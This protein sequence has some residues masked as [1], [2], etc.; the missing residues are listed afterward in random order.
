[1]EIHQLVHTLNY[2]DAISGEALAIRRILTEMGIPSRIYVVNAHE[3]V[4]EFAVDW[5]KLEGDIAHSKD[6][7]VVHHYSLGS[8]LNGLY[9]NLS[10]TRRAIIYHNLTPERW[11]ESYNYR[12]TQDLISGRKELPALLAV[13]DLALADSE[14]NLSE[15]R[16]MG[17]AEGFVL[18]LLLDEEKW[19][20]P[21]NPGIKGV[22]S[23]HGGRNFLHVGRLAPNKRLED[24]IKAF[25]FYHHKIDKQSRLWLIG[26]DID[27]EIYSFELRRLVTELRLKEAVTFVGSVADSELRS[28]YENSDLYLCMS[29]HE[30]FCVPL[31][32]AMHFGLPII[33]FD[34]CAVKDTLGGAGVLVEKKLPAA[35]AE[36]MNIIV[37][38]ATLRSQLIESGRK[39]VLGFNTRMFAAALKRELI[40]R[41]TQDIPQK[42]VASHEGR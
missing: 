27:T 13:S 18:P 40:D 5:R 30:G 6:V 26:G 20:V 32:E 8:P 4:R 33:A 23:G 41:L 3:K 35:I 31:L 36:L 15:L 22:L 21:A 11:F 19:Q 29:E 37:N 34:S 39:R 25:Y 16:E 2:G 42:R 38:D 28:F 24:I 9:L 17:V 7:S 10:G 14:Y 12:V 1:M